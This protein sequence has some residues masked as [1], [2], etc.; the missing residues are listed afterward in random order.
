MGNENT[1]YNGGRTSVNEF[2]KLVGWC[3]VGVMNER[4]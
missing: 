1:M 4:M 3:A 2:A